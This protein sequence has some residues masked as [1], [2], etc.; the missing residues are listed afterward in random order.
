MINFKYKYISSKILQTR[1]NITEYKKE[2]VDF[3]SDAFDFY[4]LFINT[5][6]TPCGIFF[7]DKYW[8]VSVSI[9]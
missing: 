3:S 7:C 4:T 1:K 9:L 5:L 8:V 6:N 2:P